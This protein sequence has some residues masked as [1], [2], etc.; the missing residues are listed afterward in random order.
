MAG[1][2]KHIGTLE[3]ITGGII[4][5]YV[6]K[7]AVYPLTVADHYVH[8]TSGTFTLTL[9]TAVGIAGRDFVMKNTG[10]GVITIA[11][12]SAQ[13]IDGAASGVLTLVQNDWLRVVSDGANW[14]ADMSGYLS[15]H[16]AVL[17]TTSQAIAIVNTPQVITFDTDVLKK[18]IVHD[19]GANPGRI[20]VNEAGHYIVHLLTTVKSTSAGTIMDIWYRIND[21][22]VPNSNAKSA[23]VNA[24]DEKPTTV[25]MT[26]EMAAGQYIEAWMSG[27]STNLSLRAAAAGA[28]PTRPVT[29][30]AYLTID[31][32]P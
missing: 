19:T 2:Q 31:R 13:T 4:R 29:P 9:P 30:S 10:A 21:A 24:N 23:I 17:D 22:D 14:F 12:T 25:T 16:G 8:C 26:V 32:L 27:D 20:T 5:P 7:T 18:K 11:T 15:P 6:A 3:I 28:V 1:T